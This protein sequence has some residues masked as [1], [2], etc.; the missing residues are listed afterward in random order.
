MKYFDKV[1]KKIGWSILI[2]L[3]LNEFAHL[4][5]KNQLK[6]NIV[7]FVGFI[8][9]FTIISIVYYINRVVQKKKS[10]EREKAKEKILD[11]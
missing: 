9:V 6:S 5:G 3:I 4:I 2:G 7:F 8:L 1:W 11:T 10:K